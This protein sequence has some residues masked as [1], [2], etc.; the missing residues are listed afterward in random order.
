M[1]DHTLR[2][3]YCIFIIL[4]MDGVRIIFI[5]MGGCVKF[6]SMGCGQ[7]HRV[8]NTHALNLKK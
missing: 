3:I 2:M 1:L 8:R 6:N 5:R 7:K 4:L